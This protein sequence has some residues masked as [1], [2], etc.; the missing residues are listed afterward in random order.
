M[1]IIDLV[2][3]VV[4]AADRDEMLLLNAKA[5]VTGSIQEEEGKDDFVHTAKQANKASDQRIFFLRLIVSQGGNCTAIAASRDTMNERL[6]DYRTPNKQ[7]Q[8]CTAIIIMEIT[9]DVFLMV[10]QPL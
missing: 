3:V 9:E 10:R 1:I 2:V 4:V 6:N 7:Q 5:S 8:Q